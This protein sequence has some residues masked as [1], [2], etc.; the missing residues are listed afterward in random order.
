MLQRIML[1]TLVGLVLVLIMGAVING[2]RRWIL[3]G[4]K[5]NMFPEIA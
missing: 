2:A 1:A 4:Q 3:I 5:D